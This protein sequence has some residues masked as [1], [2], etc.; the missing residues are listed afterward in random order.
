MELC[1][2]RTKASLL[3]AVSSKLLL[4]PYSRS[5]LAFASSGCIIEGCTT[6]SSSPPFVLVELASA[7]PTEEDGEANE[8]QDSCQNQ[9]SNT[10]P[11]VVE[12]ERV[13]LYRLILSLCQNQGH[14]SEK[15]SCE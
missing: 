8:T 15:D 14:K 10:Q 13:I 1:R 2:K 9:T 7:T 3:T 5:C 6:T 11:V 12:S 4:S